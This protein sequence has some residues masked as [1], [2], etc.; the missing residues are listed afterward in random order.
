MP[1]T[2]IASAKFKGNEEPQ[3]SVE[4]SGQ[5]LKSNPSTDDVEIKAS[6]QPAEKGYVVIETAGKYVARTTFVARDSTNP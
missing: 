4:I 1:T 5:D 2:I 6:L 3:K